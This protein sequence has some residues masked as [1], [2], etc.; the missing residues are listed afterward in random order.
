[1]LFAT[2]VG[3]SGLDLQDRRERLGHQNMG[4]L[5]GQD[6]HDA[7]EVSEHQKH[8][9]RAGSIGPLEGLDLLQVLHM[10]EERGVLVV[11]RANLRHSGVDR[12]DLALVG[13]RVTIEW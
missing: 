10:L 8:G 2:S 5:V 9:V 7:G 6:G 1:M 11:I 12:N 13:R 3:L 4:L